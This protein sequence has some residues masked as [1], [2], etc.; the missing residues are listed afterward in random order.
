M[1]RTIN[2]SAQKVAR[3]SKAEAARKAASKA[4]LKGEPVQA[5]PTSYGKD[6]IVARA[7]AE[8]QIQADNVAILQHEFTPDEMAAMAIDF[9]ALKDSGSLS[10]DA[11]FEQYVESQR[12]TP[13][14]IDPP[15]VAKAKDKTPYTGPM[16]A[17]VSARRNYAKAANGILC[18]GDQLA[19]ICGAHSRDVTVR[20]LI[21]ALKLP[22]NP[23]ARLNPGQQSMNLRNKARHAMK[24]GVLTMAEVK[25]A[26]SIEQPVK[27]T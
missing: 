8:Q 15:K 25:A 4:A 9:A 12:P 2:K 24:D 17:L 7:E 18:N 19:T 13:E 21:R 11:T 23:Y 10:S 6:P 26:Y 22:G 16:L 3:E 20:A 14:L 1:A 27:A 5:D